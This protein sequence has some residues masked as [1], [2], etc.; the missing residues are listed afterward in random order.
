VLHSRNEGAITAALD[1]SERSAEA[2]ASFLKFLRDRRPGVVSVTPAEVSIT[3]DIAHQLFTVKFTWRE[4]RIRRSDHSDYAVF[5]ATAHHS[6]GKWTS[7][8]PE[9][10]RPPES[11]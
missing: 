8:K 9:L 3:G 11:K 4:G 6:Y 10:T 5:R 7:S 1:D 2:R